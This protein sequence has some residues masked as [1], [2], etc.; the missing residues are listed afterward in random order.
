MSYKPI[1]L[2]ISVIILS[3]SSDNKC[4]INK[5]TGWF[6]FIHVDKLTDLPNILLSY[7]LT[8]LWKITVVYLYLE[9]GYFFS[10][11]SK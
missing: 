11:A 8:G 10:L 3:N 4:L 5:K 7:N 6:H 2:I 1:Q 9:K